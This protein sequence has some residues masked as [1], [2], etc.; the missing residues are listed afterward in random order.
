MYV[1]KTDWGTLRCV[2]YYVDETIGLDVFVVTGRSVLS[3]EEVLA[4]A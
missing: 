3:E 4:W 2:V 1:N